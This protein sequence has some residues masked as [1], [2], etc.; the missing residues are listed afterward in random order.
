VLPIEIKAGKTGSLKSLHTFMALKK[1]KR[2]VRFNTDQPSIVM[3]NTTIPG[4][5]AAHYKLISL[6]LYM[7]GQLSRIITTTQ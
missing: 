6:P 7:I 1:I 4:I 5:G 2:A 3:V